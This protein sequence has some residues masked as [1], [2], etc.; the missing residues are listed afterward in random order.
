[1]PDAGNVRPMVNPWEAL[2]GR[3]E[4]AAA[5]AA[6][7]TSSSAFSTEQRRAVEREVLETLPKLEARRAAELVVRVHSADGLRTEALLDGIGRSLTLLVPRFGS[8][9]LTRLT[10]AAAAWALEIAGDVDE[11]RLRLSDPMRSFFNAVAAEVSL[12]LMDVAPGDLARIASSLASLGLGDARLFA[13]IARAAVARNDRFMPSELV[14]LVAAFDQARYYQTSLFEALAKCLKLHIK[15]TA[16]KDVVSG[17]R[18]LAA[19]GIRD[20]ELGKAVGESLPK[21]AGAGGLSAED[22]CTLAWTFC[23]LDLHHD[24]LFRAV[25]RALEDASVVATEAL[26]Q[27]YEIHLALK[28]FHQ[29]SYGGYELEDGTVQSLREHYR[30]HKGGGNRAV[31]LERSSERVHADVAELLKDVLDASVSTSPQMALG[32]TVDVAATK[33]RSSSSS[34]FIF[35]EID[36]P[37]SLVRSLDP[38]DAAGSFGAAQA[39][40]VKGA[41][42]LKR[43]VLQRHG[44]RLGVVNEDEWR[45][46]STSREKREL[47]RDICVKAGVSED[48]LL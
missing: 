31:R 32:F 45:T 43:R 16:P 13:S 21:R 44:F 3:I 22:F 7:T 6:A 30:K 1:M 27:L 23:A 48:R 4:A 24:K 42:A 35:V 20:E 17:M 26:C 40:R 47:L 41:A 8:P 38:M 19:C 18:L 2:L 11:N 37:H 29:D 46:M 15:D 10:A 33:R 25:F 34:P 5:A 14:A 28:A 39:S 9:D 12:R 36:G